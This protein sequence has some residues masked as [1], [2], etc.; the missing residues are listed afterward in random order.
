[1]FS[2]GLFRLGVVVYT[3]RRRYILRDMTKHLVEL[4][5][6]ALSAARSELG[7]LTIKDTVNE[8]LRRASSDRSRRVIAALDVL[9]DA[10]LRD[11]EDAWR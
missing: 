4:D 11:R 10:D 2:Y 8:A 7:T 1:M 9:A 3:V 6:A 5:E